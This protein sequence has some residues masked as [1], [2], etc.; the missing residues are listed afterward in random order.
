VRTWTAR[1][2]GW[3][4]FFSV[5]ILDNRTYTWYISGGSAR[6]AETFRG[7][8]ACG[9]GRFEPK[10]KEVV[11]RLGCNCC[12]ENSGRKKAAR[13]ARPCDDKLPEG[14]RKT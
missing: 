4:W 7:S 3:L 13:V 12:V 11:E 6:V 5:I 14:H 8:W 2:W 10:D 9:A 1:D